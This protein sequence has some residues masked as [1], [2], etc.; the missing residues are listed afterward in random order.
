M[1]V[2]CQTYVR[3]EL[4]RRAKDCLAEVWRA[5]LLHPLK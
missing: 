3:E 2:S 4:K 5:R 1:F